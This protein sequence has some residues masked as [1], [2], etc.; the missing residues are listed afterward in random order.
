MQESLGLKVS[1][2]VHLMGDEAPSQAQKM[3]LETEA[4]ARIQRLVERLRLE[5][6][7]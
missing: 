3:L 2:F 6:E 5:E 4:R 7:G 1:Q